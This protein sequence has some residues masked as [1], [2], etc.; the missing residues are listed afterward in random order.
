MKKPTKTQIFNF[1][2]VN[3]GCFLFAFGV[4]VFRN[5]NDFASGGMSGLSLLLSAFFPWAPVGAIMMVLNVFVLG[6]GYLFLGKKSTVGSVYGTF[7]LSGFI[8]LLEIFIPLSGPITDARFMEL[9][10]SV[11]IPG[12]GMALVFHCG[13]TTG[14]TDIVAQILSKYFKW[15]VSVSLLVT[16]FLIALGAGLI[17][18]VEAMLYSVLGVFL[19]T[20]L[21]DAVMENLKTRKIIVVISDKSAEI[22]QFITVSL[23]RGATISRAHGAYSMQEKDVITTVLNRRQAIKLQQFIKSVDPL[24]FITISNSTEIIGQGFDGF[25][26]FE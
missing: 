22:Q 4:V 13:A 6:L 26:L 20:F 9:I 12:F 18:S 11:F 2:G 23:N 8:W 19:R 15:K 16:D 3:L 1:L 24:A 25:E 17:F 7:A 10:Y 21:M 14:G 5:P